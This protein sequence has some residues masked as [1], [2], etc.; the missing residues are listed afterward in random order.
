MAHIIPTM[1]LNKKDHSH[2]ERAAHEA[3]KSQMLMKHGC[4]V[5]IGSKVIS[6]GYNSSR[7]QFGDKFISMS[8]S[9]H[10]EMSALRKIFKKDLKHSKEK[11]LKQQK[12]K[13]K[14]RQKPKPK[15]KLQQKHS[16]VTSHRKL[17]QCEKVA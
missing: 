4:V 10:A 5:A 9:C 11:Q 6:T 16:C 7:N 17:K 12:L 13:Q 14:L 3:T 1:T 15:Q 8:C 2:I